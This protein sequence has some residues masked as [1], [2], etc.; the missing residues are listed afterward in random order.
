MNKKRII[1]VGKAASGKDHARKKLENIG[2]KYCISHTTRPKRKDEIDGV[3]YYFI[4]MDFMQENFISKNLLYE[5]VIFNG[6]IY[7]TT[8]KEFNESDLFIM[9]P[10]GIKR[11]DPIDREESFIIYI[12]I[13]YDTREKRLLKRG[14][15]DSS[16]RR[17][18]ADEK[19]FENFIDFDHRIDNPNFDIIE[20]LDS[21]KILKNIL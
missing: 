15:A 21:L 14:D 19:D 1:L 2:F 6:W 3:D 8:I 17:L 16:E 12:D 5:W 10:T 4:S 11:L 13:D 20:I 7:G 9:T 18:I